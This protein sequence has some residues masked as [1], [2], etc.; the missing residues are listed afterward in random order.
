MESVHVK[1]F[2]VIPKIAVH[3]IQNIAPGPPVWIAI[4]TPAILPIPTVLERAL[5][6]A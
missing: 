3:H 1:N 2:V 5:D 6:K 4:A